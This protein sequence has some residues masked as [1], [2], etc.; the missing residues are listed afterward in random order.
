M[1]RLSKV[2]QIVSGV[3]IGVF[4]FFGSISFL[5]YAIFYKMSATPSK[6]VF[7]EENSHDKSNN[8]SITNNKTNISS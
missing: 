3:L 6:P 8:K 1:N 4:L 5:A 7:F 2:S